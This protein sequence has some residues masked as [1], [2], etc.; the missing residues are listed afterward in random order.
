MRERFIDHRFNG[1]SE[2]WNDV[3]IEADEIRKNMVKFVK[4]FKPV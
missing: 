3:L 2:A 1:E 4:G